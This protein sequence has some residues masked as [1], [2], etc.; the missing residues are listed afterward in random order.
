MPDIPNSKALESSNVLDDIKLFFVA[1][2]FAF[3]ASALT[4]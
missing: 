3:A 2:L 4:S 1:S